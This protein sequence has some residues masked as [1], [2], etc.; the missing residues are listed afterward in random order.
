MF[1]IVDYPE[2]IMHMKSQAGRAYD[3]NSAGWHGCFCPFCDDQTRKFN[4]SHGHFWVSSTFPYGHCFRCGTKVSLYAFL[5]TT[6]FAN[7]AILER[8]KKLSKFSYSGDTSRATSFD[9]YQVT[10]ADQVLL[11]MQQTYSEVQKKYPNEYVKY[12]NYINS[13]CLEINPIRFLMAPQIYQKGNVRTINVSFTNFD[14]QLVTARSIDSAKSRYYKN[15]GQKQ[16]Y[17]FQD[18]NYIDEYQEIVICEGAFDL[19]NLYTYYPQFKNSFFIAIG[20]SNYKGLITNLVNT[21][22]LIGEYDLRI[23]FDKGVKRLDQLKTNILNTTNILNPQIN[24]EMYEPALSKDV[25]ELMLL[26]Q[27]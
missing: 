15:S 18:I 11:K 3:V 23:V 12:K 7:G 26:N 9:R 8:L 27:I 10:P 4:P 1:N 13:R 19:I 17:F 20:D 24:V 6:G 2:V 21:F 16:F 5:T 14:G 25:S 22:L